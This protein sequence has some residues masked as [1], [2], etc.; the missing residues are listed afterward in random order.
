MVKLADW[1]KAAIA[2]LLWDIA[3]KADNLWSVRASERR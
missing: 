3:K 1:N 2:K